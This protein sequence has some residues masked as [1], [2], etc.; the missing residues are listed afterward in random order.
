MVIVTFKAPMSMVK[1]L[2]SVACALKHTRSH[3]IRLAIS[4]F[5]LRL[6]G[7]GEY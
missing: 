1:K 3:L 2:D 7:N 5:L 4:E 6:E